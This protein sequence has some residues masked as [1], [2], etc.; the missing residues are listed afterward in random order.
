MITYN[1][2]IE[3]IHLLIVEVDKQLN[4]L[5]VHLTKD[6]KVSM[7]KINIREDYIDSLKSVILKKTYRLI[8]LEQENNET[9]IN[10][11]M[12]YSTIASNLEK[13]GDYIENIIAQN[14]YFKSKEFL[15]NF[16]IEKY[17][18]EIFGALEF[19]KICLENQD[20][21]L[22]IKICNSE[23]KIDEHYA[24]D[25]KAI[26]K[27]LKKNTDQTGDLLTVLFIVRYFERIG[28]AFLNIGEAL[29]SKTVGTRIKISHFHAINENFDTDEVDI[30][31]VGEETRSGCTIEK[32]TNPDSKNEKLVE[33]IF[34]EGR[35]EKL[36][37][38]KEQVEQWLKI[39]PGTAPKVIN[40]QEHEET[41]LLLTE[42]VHGKNFQEILVAGQMPV[43]V[44]SF[45]KFIS[46]L[47]ANWDQTK[48]DLA[49]EPNHCKQL[50]K[51]IGNVYLVHP[52][53][54]RQCSIIGT[55]NNLKIEDLVKKCQ[56]IEEKV[57]P[58]FSVFIHGD[59]NNDNFIYNDEEDKIFFIDL[60]RS[61][62]MD[63]TQD[64]SV[65]L[66]SNFRIPFFETVIRE[67]INSVNENFF[68]FA[69]NYAEE[70]S[71]ETF[72]YRLAFGL[73]R[74]FITSCRFSKNYKHVR[75]MF[76]RGKFI[77]NQL[78]NYQGK[79]EDFKVS[80]DLLLS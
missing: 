23:N 68:K 3:N 45:K 14:Q 76:L 29:I 34:K 20:N 19:L 61:R 36:I 26:V 7:S 56:V 16:D 10:N 72:Q 21:N 58:E 69:C 66:V 2:L 25:F 4:D 15:Y 40:Y 39:F 75:T 71:D 60:H 49:I 54:E 65:F 44:K 22:A 64:V 80:I 57:Q 46:T 53:I 1:A 77:F 27:L 28:D 47:K 42:F 38:E 31:N 8:S 33:V 5:R 50:L 74:S 51:R 73:A 24:K 37:E 70:N 67:K 55:H 17:F 62:R 13:I 43:L 63:Y 6:K 32:I 52:L 48:Q 41:G 79:P 18:I 78:L 12:V 59:M 30:K 35:K 11:L 9:A